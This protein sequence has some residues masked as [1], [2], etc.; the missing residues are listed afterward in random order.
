MPKLVFSLALDVIAMPAPQA[1]VER[2]FSVCGLLIS[3]HR[4]RMEKSIQMHIF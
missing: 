3:G 4:N 1:I 2:L